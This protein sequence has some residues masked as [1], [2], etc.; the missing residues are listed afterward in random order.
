M[1]AKGV[2]T[3]DGGRRGACFAGKGEEAIT[4]RGEAKGGKRAEGGVPPTHPRGQEGRRRECGGGVIRRA[5]VFLVCAWAGWLAGVQK[6]GFACEH[7]ARGA[8]RGGRAY[9]K[10]KGGRGGLYVVGEREA[11]RKCIGGESPPAKARGGAEQGSLESKKEGGLGGVH[12]RAGAGQAGCSRAPRGHRGWR[13]SGDGG[14]V[15]FVP[16]WADARR[17]RA[18]RG[19]WGLFAGVCGCKRSPEGCV[20]GVS[21]G[22]CVKVEKRGRAQQREGA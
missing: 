2:E 15:F 8:P 3:V 17:A 13:G 5:G 9:V 11:G 22:V 19:A 18:G 6:G 12:I 14:G 10:R 7:P 16:R 21:V 4:P 1:G 20:R